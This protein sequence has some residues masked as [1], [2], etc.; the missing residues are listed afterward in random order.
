M[1]KM[2]AQ[3]AERLNVDVEEL[4]KNYKHLSIIEFKE[5]TRKRD[6]E[7]KAWKLASIVWQEDGGRNVE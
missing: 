1:D 2:T 4:L 7:N 5:W 3:L 6:P